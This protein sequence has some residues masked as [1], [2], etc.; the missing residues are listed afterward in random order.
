[1]NVVKDVEYQP[2]WQVANNKQEEAIAVES[3]EDEQQMFNRVAFE[4]ERILYN[5]NGAQVAI[6][7]LED[8]VVLEAMDRDFFNGLEQN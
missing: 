5:M 3:K 6:V 2:V 7:P 1:M 4:G 8:Y